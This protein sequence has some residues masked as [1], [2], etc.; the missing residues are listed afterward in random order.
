MRRA[1]RCI[2]RRATALRVVM[3][4][5]H[6]SSMDNTLMGFDDDQSVTF[7]SGVIIFVI[8]T[9]LKFTLLKPSGYYMYRDVQV[10]IER[11]AS[12]QD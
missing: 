8:G 10:Q 2:L 7:E 6:C 4:I 3:L 1:K 9:V 11:G 5:I 12:E